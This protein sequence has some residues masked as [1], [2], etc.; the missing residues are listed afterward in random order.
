[1]DAS[2]PT[3]NRDPF[4]ERVAG[5]IDNDE[6]RR[7]DSTQESNDEVDKSEQ[8]YPPMLQWTTRLRDFL[9]DRGYEIDPRT[10]QVLREA[11]FIC[12]A[13]QSKTKESPR[14][15]K[16]SS[17]PGTTAAD[18]ATFPKDFD[19][20][21]FWG[22]FNRI[23][24]LPVDIFP[25]NSGE[26][27]QHETRQHL[28]N[29][30]GTSVDWFQQDVALIWLSPTVF[31]SNAVISW[32]SANTGNRNLLKLYKVTMEMNPAYGSQGVCSVYIYCLEYF[33]KYKRIK[34][35]PPLLP[36]SLFR[37]MISRLP[38][39]FFT[40]ITFTEGSPKFSPSFYSAFLASVLPTSEEAHPPTKSKNYQ[41]Y[42][43][44]RFPGKM[45][46][47]TLGA[48]LQHAFHP[49]V[50]LAFDRLQET[51]LDAERVNWML[52][53]GSNHLRHLKI[54]KFLVK[55]I[56]AVNDN[57]AFESFA[58]N[59]HLE[60]L[61][62]DWTTSSRPIDLWNTP[63][64]WN[65]AGI[66]PVILDGIAS[67]PKFQRLT[68]RFALPD[69]TRLGYDDDFL[70]MPPI[71]HNLTCLFKAVIPEH[72]SFKEL[73]VHVKTN[74]NETYHELY[75]EGIDCLDA[76]RRPLG[77]SLCHLSYIH[78]CT[79][80]HEPGWNPYENSPFW[81]LYLAPRLMMNWLFFQSPT[82][83]RHESPRWALSKTPEERRKRARRQPAA[84]LLALQIRA[85]NE[86]ILYRKTTEQLPHDMG[87]A[88]AT[89]MQ[90]LVHR[91]LVEV[92]D[93]AAL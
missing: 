2:I 10:W 11:E 49:Y 48:I 19:F 89:V 4:H 50:R 82:E 71:K 28:Q 47:H 45:T 59:P 75:A 85:I 77:N 70:F 9:E 20:H 83:Q 26:H 65:Y 55:Y 25:P 56:P 80:P 5:V 57:D 67:N 92:E 16:S 86:G 66:S 74:C 69:C 33:H 63:P 81:D 38:V 37:H 3:I 46:F 78:E 91:V 18:S 29:N 24:Y 60:T 8:S 64:G 21:V 17:D 79:D 41:E 36:L 43:E 15:R 22:C 7:D 13:S 90:V 44:V 14:K 35:P 42:T 93:V 27:P 1:M 61:T 54:P 39:D 68:L 84:S 62:M 40:S 87:P 34:P 51:S 88:N 6:C 30:P 76:N 73:T 53:Y 72:S 31:I 23:K 12:H 32:T 52:R 58:A